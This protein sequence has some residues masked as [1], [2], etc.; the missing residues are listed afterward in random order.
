MSTPTP[1]PYMAVEA[2]R[3]KFEARVKFN[4]ANPKGCLALDTD[5]EYASPFIYAMW[6]EFQAGADFAASRA[7]VAVGVEPSR[8]LFIGDFEYRVTFLRDGHAEVVRL[9]PAPSAG[10]GGSVSAEPGQDERPSLN[11]LKDRM[12]AETE[13]WKTVGAP[14]YL[15]PCMKAVTDWRCTRVAGHDGPCAAT[16]APSV[17]LGGSEVDN[18]AGWE[19]LA[20]ALAREEHD[21]IH[22]LIWEGGPV[23]EPWGEVWQKYE[24]DASRMIAL[25]REHAAHA[26]QAQ[27]AAPVEPKGDVFSTLKTVTIAPSGLLEQVEKFSEANGEADFETA[28]ALG[29]IEAAI[30]FDHLM[31]DAAPPAGVQGDAARLTRKQKYD[32]LVGEAIERAAKELPLG[33][34]VDISIEQGAG[35]VTWS[36]G[37]G[38]TTSICDGEAF[39]FDINAAV[40]AAISA[41]STKGA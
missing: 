16:P 10:A 41:Q 40:D 22:H 36:D 2:M 25:V 29:L 32:L 39:H 18:V 30:K 12:R 33:C 34:Y 23:P 21:D 9:G 27:D 38:V 14:E 20:M 8:D 24:G 15:Q 3:E 6:T 19:M 1:A 13:S 7:P 37:K 5:G 4:P 31:T 28:E 35:S 26:L 11:T 17:P